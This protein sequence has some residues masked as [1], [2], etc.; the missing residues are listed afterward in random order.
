MGRVPNIKR[1]QTNDFNEKDQELI[2]TL[3]YPINSFME[4]TAAVLDKGVDFNNL[5]QAIITLQTMTDANGNPILETKYKSLLKSKVVGHVC[6]NAYN[7]T[8]TSA[9]PVNTPFISFIQNADIVTINN[10]TGLQANNKYK[11]I[12]LSIGE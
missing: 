3:A 5:N 10:I 4:Q 1:I 7:I 6:I 9:F 2:S 12:V 11:L 8:N